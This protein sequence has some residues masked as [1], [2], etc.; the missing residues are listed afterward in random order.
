MGTFLKRSGGDIS[1]AIQHFEP[2]TWLLRAPDL[3]IL[4]KN[5]RRR[6]SAEFHLGNLGLHFAEERNMLRLIVVA[7]ILAGFVPSSRAG[8]AYTD[9]FEGPNLNPFWTPSISR[10]SLSFT[11]AGAHSGTNG[12]QLESTSVAG[13]R[14]WKATCD[15]SGCVGSHTGVERRSDMSHHGCAG[16]AGSR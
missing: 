12:A 1:K 15:A 6:S 11:P 2:R 10:G 8:V 14:T 7:V 3:G 13:R 9:G 4:R 16:V 5:R